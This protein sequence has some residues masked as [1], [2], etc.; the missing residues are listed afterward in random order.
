MGAEE[1]AEGAAAEAAPP[2]P[3]PA[4]RAGPCGGVTPDFAFPLAGGD[5]GG[6]PA[7]PFAGAAEAAAAAAGEPTIGPHTPMHDAKVTAAAAAATATATAAAG[8]AALPCRPQALT[9]GVP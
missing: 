2:T 5:A 6:T 8:R 9:R 1:A 7:T 4:A 3:P